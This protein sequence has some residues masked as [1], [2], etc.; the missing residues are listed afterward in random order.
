MNPLFLGNDGGGDEDPDEGPDDELDEDE[1]GNSTFNPSN[2]PGLNLPP[3]LSWLNSWVNLSLAFSMLCVNV[4]V[5]KR[6]SE[7]FDDPGELE[8]AAP[9]G[10]VAGS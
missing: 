2:I 4:E 8:A 5:S 3:G 10:D 1:E 7:S 9:D 6:S